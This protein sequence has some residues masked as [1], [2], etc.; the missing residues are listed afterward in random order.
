MKTG[1]LIKLLLKTRL[2][3]LLRSEY[4]TI[5]SVQNPQIKQLIKLYQKVSARRDG[6]V[7]PVEGAREI[8][9]ALKSGYIMDV[10]YYCSEIPSKTGPLNPSEMKVASGK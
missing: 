1:K 9:R 3:L 4:M 10:L 5:N 8:D 2:F 7:F 6:G